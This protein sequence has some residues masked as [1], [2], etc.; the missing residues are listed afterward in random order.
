MTGSDHS[1]ERQRFIE[2]MAL[3]YEK[4]CHT[5]MQ[6]RIIAW[7]MICEPPHQTAGEI[8]AGLQA[9]KASIS[10]NIR[11]FVD[12]GVIE[13]FTRPP[14]RRD[15]YRL[16]D[17]AWARAVERGFPLIAAFGSLAERGLD[18]VGH[19]PEARARLQEMGEFYEFYERELRAV[20]ARWERGKRAR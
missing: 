19:E 11:M 4:A 20:L 17:D 13:R 15:F 5:R 2:D 6:G 9:S 10:T 7:L 12:F 3:L 8:A 14:E 1:E 18:L 16:G